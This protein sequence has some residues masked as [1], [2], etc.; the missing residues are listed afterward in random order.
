M[1]VTQF[2]SL[3]TIKK[4]FGGDGSNMPKQ[5]DMDMTS[6]YENSVKQTLFMAT[7]FRGQYLKFSL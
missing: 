3:D 4:V 5:M 6:H 1:Y 7:I 2:S